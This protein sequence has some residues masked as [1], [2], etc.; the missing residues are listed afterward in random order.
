MACA[1]G[2][3]GPPFPKCQGSPASKTAE[4]QDEGDLPDHP[5]SP[6]ERTSSH[7]HHKE[8]VEQTQTIWAQ[9]QRSLSHGRPRA[10][11]GPSQRGREHRGCYLGGKSTSQHRELLQRHGEALGGW[12]AG[13]VASPSTRNA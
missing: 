6:S 3:Q 8:E 2:G 5:T 9:K 12:G 7:L 13:A 1:S 4:A 10:P 11:P